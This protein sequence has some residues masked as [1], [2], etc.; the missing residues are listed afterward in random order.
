MHAGMLL[1]LATARDSSRT[2]ALSTTQ[3]IRGL[4]LMPGASQCHAIPADSLSVT[5]IRS[6]VPWYPFNMD[7]VSRIPPAP[8]P[9]LHCLKLCEYYSVCSRGGLEKP[10]NT[11]PACR[12]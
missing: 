1:V 6:E 3:L 7:G 9:T 8:K 11:L 4:R 12:V 2:L 5:G 10:N